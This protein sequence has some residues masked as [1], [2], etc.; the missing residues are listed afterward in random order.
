[1]ARIGRAV[2]RPFGALVMVG[3]VAGL[4]CWALGLAP[5]WERSP[6]PVVSVL[7][8][9]VLLAPAA[10]VWTHRRRIEKA[11]LATPG[12]L[13]EAERAIAAATNLRLDPLL[14]SARNRRQGRPDPWWR[15]AWAF[16]RAYAGPLRRAQRAHREAIDQFTELLATFSPVAFAMSGIAAAACL[17]LVLA[18]PVVALVRLLL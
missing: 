17:V 1:M 3:F 10:L 11:L 18:L 12:L 4:L 14:R 16:A 13:D 5:W 9:A 8:L 6:R 7:W 2:L 15:E